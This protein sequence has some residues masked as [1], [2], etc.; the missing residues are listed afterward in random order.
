MTVDGRCRRSDNSQAHVTTRGAD[1]R[2]LRVFDLVDHANNERRVSQQHQ[3][4]AFTMRTCRNGSLRV[5]L[6]G[7]FLVAH[8]RLVHHA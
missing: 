1:N 8:G 4:G 2:L 3:P 7:R 5:P 6:S